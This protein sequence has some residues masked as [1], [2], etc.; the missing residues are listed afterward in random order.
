MIQGTW[1]IIEL[2]VVLY[3]YV[4]TKG[5]TLEEIDEIF[6]GKHLLDTEKIESPYE[7]DSDK[8]EAGEVVT[9]VET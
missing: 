3:F 8:K 6:D 1:D 9:V 7:A 2:A 4:D 5:K